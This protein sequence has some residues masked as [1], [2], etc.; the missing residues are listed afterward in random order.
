MVQYPKF[1]TLSQQRM[2]QIYQ[3][4]INEV[5]DQNQ[6]LKSHPAPESKINGWLHKIC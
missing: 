5:V 3:Q 4:G 2:D 1:F 6:R